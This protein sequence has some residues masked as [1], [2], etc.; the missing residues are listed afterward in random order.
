MKPLILILHDTFV[1]A[2]R[3]DVTD[4]AAEADYIAAGLE[5]LGYEAE[6]EPVGLD[7]TA[8]ERSLARRRPLAVFNLV[9]SLGGQA[10]LIAAVPSLLE[11]R[12]IPFTGCAADAQALSSNKLL[13]KQWLAARG[14]ATPPLFSGGAPPTTAAASVVGGAPA[15]DAAASA[16]DWIVKSVWEHA[17]FGIDDASI[18]PASAVDD[19][20][21]RRRRQHGGRWFAEAFVPGRE[22]NLA[23]LAQGGRVLSLPPAEIRFDAYPE[24]KPHVV[25]YAAKWEASSFEYAHTP[26]SFEI[27]PELTARAAE[28]ALACWEAFGLAGY[29]RVDFR[30]DAA[31][32]P[33]VLEV[34]ANP[35]LSPDAGFA[36]ALEAAGIEFE[37]A[38]SWLVEDALSRAVAASQESKHVPHT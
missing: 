7:L 9:E 11:A 13:A 4:V 24:G 25:G 14:I 12:G 3:I 19:L 22:L 34:N 5:A 30:I 2:S 8:L 38:L 33:W 1:S 20:L 21:A 31:G 37:A 29:A 26:R 32:R 27:E 16:A 17:S 36:A 35:C 18:V 10:S 6:I 15:A 28:Q 23:L